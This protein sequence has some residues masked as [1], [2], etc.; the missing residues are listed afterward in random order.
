MLL[1]PRA[2][3]S[4]GAEGSGQVLKGQREPLGDCKHSRASSP[5][6]HLC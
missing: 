5:G 2:A 6:G 1:G 4:E 3:G